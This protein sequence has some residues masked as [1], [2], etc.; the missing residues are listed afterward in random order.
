M[1]RESLEVAFTG[2]SC[3]FIL[4]GSAYSKINS[5]ME[6]SQVPKFTPTSPVFQVI[7][8]PYAER[9][10]VVLGRS[11]LFEIVLWR[12]CV[13]TSQHPALLSSQLTHFLSHLSKPGVLTQYS[14]YGTDNWGIGVPFLAGAKIFLFPTGSRAPM[15]PAQPSMQWVSGVLSREVEGPLTLPSAEIKDAWSYT[16]TSPSFFMA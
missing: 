8:A 7:P 11:M 6:R 9:F 14:D 1:K 12:S 13:C 3:T 5:C 15:G 4:P 16:S 10:F 2:L